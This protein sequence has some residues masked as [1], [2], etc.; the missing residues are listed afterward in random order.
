M[1]NRSPPMNRMSTLGAPTF[2]LED[3][4]LVVLQRFRV[5]EHLTG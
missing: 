3:D 1:S 2:V 4:T 5:V